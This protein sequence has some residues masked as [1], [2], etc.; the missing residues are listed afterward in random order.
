MRLRLFL[1]IFKKSEKKQTTFIISNI[2]KNP[3][4]VLEQAT[5]LTL[6]SFSPVL[7]STSKW[8]PCFPIYYS[9]SSSILSLLSKFH[10]DER[11]KKNTNI[12]IILMLL[13]QCRDMD[14]VL[15]R[16]VLKMRI[17]VR[18]SKLK[19]IVFCNRHGAM[20]GTHFTTS[21][22]WLYWYEILML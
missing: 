12:A 20:V 13:S 7:F 15:F 19:H 17:S 10:E 4:I 18:S 21:S 8:V 3:I 2:K 9:W 1:N 16:T 22:S 5:R 6:L 14:G 11:N